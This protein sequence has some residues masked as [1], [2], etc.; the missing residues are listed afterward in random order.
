MNIYTSYFSNL[1]NIPSDF[2]PVAICSGIP[3]W[4]KGIWTKM[5]APK[6]DFFNEWKQ[7]HDNNFYIEHFNKEV[8]DK[9]SPEIFINLL[10]NITN[11]AENIVL[12]CYEKPND[13][14][15]RHLVADWLNK[16]TNYEVKEWYKNKGE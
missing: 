11:N 5:V 10:K 1:R 4:Y 8:L 6:W 15:H 14:C 13:F 3:Y 7:N 12:I 2:V 16:N 9:T